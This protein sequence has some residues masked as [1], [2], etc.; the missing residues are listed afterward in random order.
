[1]AGTAAGT[2]VQSVSVFWWG[3]RSDT[4]PSCAGGEESAHTE[5]AGFAADLP[6]ETVV[7]M[8]I[9]VGEVSNPT[10]ED[11]A[12]S[13]P[14]PHADTPL[15]VDLRGEDDDDVAEDEPNPAGARDKGKNVQR[16]ATLHLQGKT[17][18][19]T[20]QRESKTVEQVA[21]KVAE[22]AVRVGSMEDTIRSLTPLIH[23][24]RPGGSHAASGSPSLTQLNT[25]DIDVPS[26]TGVRPSPFMG[27]SGFTPASSPGG[28]L[29]VATT[30][31][32]LAPVSTLDEALLSDLYDRLKAL[33]DTARERQPSRDRGSPAAQDEVIEKIKA[34][35]QELSDKVET[36]KADL[37][38]W[39]QKAMTRSQQI[40]SLENELRRRVQGRESASRASSSRQSIP[41]PTLSPTLSPTLTAPLPPALPS[42]DPARASASRAGSSRPSIPPPTLSPTLSPTLTAPLPPA[43]PSADPARASASPDVEGDQEAMEVEEAC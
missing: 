13:G 20:V 24:S 15:P 19:K 10:A 1:M 39:N 22:L 43:L 35:I 36:A 14:H 27:A 7:G 6:E 16:S 33:E 23:L 28:R 42:A 18:G 31:A 8:D 25:L 40:E 2:W 3:V 12:E 34:Q 21:A 41:P 5:L 17:A 11:L 32:P 26:S 4:E 37:A 30:Q 9:D 29:P 38:G